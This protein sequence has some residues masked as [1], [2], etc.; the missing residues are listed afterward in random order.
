M[1]GDIEPAIG[2]IANARREPKP[3]QVAQTEHMI[4]CAGR[5]GVMLA[6]VQRAFVMQET[7]KNMRG[8]A[9][10]GRVTKVSR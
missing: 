3:Q 10:I 2:E 6:D 4:N 1:V 8:F 7:I 5:V 9:R